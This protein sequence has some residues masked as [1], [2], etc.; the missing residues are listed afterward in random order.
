MNPNDTQVA[1]N[2]YRV[3]YQHWD[4]ALDFQ[5][6]YFDGQVTKY[7]TRHRRKNGKQD[8]MKAMHF[9]DK[10]E[11]AMFQGRVPWAV[12][13]PMGGEQARWDT[14][15]YIKDNNLGEHETRVITATCIIRGKECVPRV[16]AAIQA[17]LDEYD[18]EAGS[19]YVNQDR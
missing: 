7:I 13:L 11:H 8:V 9:L 17:I 19:G 4:L 18:A 1:G 5:L 15:R 16:R 10:W 14:A 3:Q 12:P 2:H 6:G